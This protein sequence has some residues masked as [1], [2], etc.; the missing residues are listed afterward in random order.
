[1]KINVP[2]KIRNI[3]KN[4]TFIVDEAGMSDSQV[5]CFDN[6]VLKIEK[7]REESD[8]EHR[9]MK[10]L[11]DKLPVPRVIVSE[12]QE[13]VNYLLMS[14][15]PGNMSC[16]KQYMENTDLLCKLLADGLRMLWKVDIKDCPYENTLDNKLR[17]AEERVKAGLCDTENCEKDT[18]G[19]NG[20]KNPEDLLQWLKCN[21]PEEEL[22]FSHGDYCLPNIFV[23]NDQI[24]GFIDLGRSGVADK[25]QDIALCYRS[26]IHNADGTYDKIYSDVKPDKIFELLGIEPDWNKINYYI[27]LDELF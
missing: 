24:S 6:M 25:Y 9:M 22:V 3:I 11:E 8:N 5:I 14:R 1:M 4:K 21:R 26:L 10:W 13:N 12:R 27:L 7:S 2:L 15:I 20:F 16:D 17:L 18:Y 23:K 19:E